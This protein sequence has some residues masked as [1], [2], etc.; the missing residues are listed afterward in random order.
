MQYHLNGFVPGNLQQSEIVRKQ[1]S[2]K[3]NTQLPRK[4]DVLIIGCGPAG[5]TLARQLA[6]FQE[7]ET[8][9]I[10]SKS[11]PLQF[12]QADG[13]SCRTIEIMEAYNS[14]EHILKESYWL[15]QIAYW[16]SDKGDQN[17]IIRTK[18]V[19]DPRIG[20]SEFPHV[21]LNQAR[22]HD[23]LLE[24]M[25]NSPGCIEPFYESEL[26][27]IKLD[28]KIQN[29]L[30]SYPITATIKQ[31]RKD[32]IVTKEI[33]T[34]YLVGCDGA[35]S[36]VRKG[37]N[38]PLLGDTTD[39]A[40]GVMDALVKTDF[41][42][43]RVKCFIKTKD[44]G[45]A[46]V[47]PREGGY[48]VRLYIELEER[49]KNKKLSI[50]NTSL[51]ELIDNTKQIFKP[52]KFEIKE[53]P[54]WSVYKI[55]QRVAS[56]FD[57]LSI[58]K[59]MIEYP[60]V[61][62][63]GDACHT[64][65]PKAGQGMNVSIHD[66]FNLGW[67]LSSV[68]LERANPI[69]LSTYDKE[70]RAVAQDL[71][72]LDRDFA[73]LVSDKNK[74][75]DN[76]LSKKNNTRKIESYFEKQTGFIAGT[77]IKYKKSLLISDNHYQNL[78]KGFTLGMRFHSCKVKRLADGRICQLGHLNKADGRWR[79]FIFSNDTKL[80]KNSKI[81]KLLKF[82]FESKNS[83]I[84]MYTPNNHDVD[85]VIDVINVF[86]NENEI[87][88]DNLV[89]THL[90]PMKGRYKLRDYEKIYNSI[91]NDDIFLKRKIDKKIGCLVVIRPDQ[92]IGCI[93]SLDD[94]NMISSYFDP[95]MNSNNK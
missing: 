70:R 86:Q 18:K 3:K 59:K 67:K 64:H 29:C 52:Y 95:I 87:S 25:L 1:S 77:N 47:I 78:A 2:L 79:I 63:A 43:I 10:E 16:D 21:V 53:I 5:L 72:N 62:I 81:N 66:A 36:M 91:P 76:P 49:K 92:H 32:Q 31:I 71:I 74:N 34:R 12:G 20:L 30:N 37:L 73:G 80:S 56:S 65:S 6:T 69:I 19:D 54:W 28:K 58:E 22:I 4:T 88:L 44:N 11:G 8:C 45:S 46:L 40:W 55:G 9:V 13:V 75:K 60:R 93:S 94:Y 57:N 51:E 27:D 83:P 38:I 84:V 7:I 61:F 35:K 48:L 82:L 90:V 24:G 41:P 39:I 42:D 17:R 89:N 23:M 33:K 15:N 26:L 68:L 50:D 14:S 85:S